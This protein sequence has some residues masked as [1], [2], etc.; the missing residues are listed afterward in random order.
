[1]TQKGS[2]MVIG[3]KRMWISQK[4]EINTVMHTFKMWIMSLLL[5]PEQLI[6]R[7]WKTLPVA[8]KSVQ[9]P[10]TSPIISEK[11]CHSTRMVDSRASAAQRHKA[12]QFVLFGY[13]SGTNFNFGI[14]E[15]VGESPST[16]RW[17][18]PTVRVKV[19][20]KHHK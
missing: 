17:E 18:V 7:F 19:L 13:A 14:K 9:C 6:H 1:M 12:A 5:W 4:C 3:I 11:Q 10:S 2:I 8:S 16:W 15:W 20:L